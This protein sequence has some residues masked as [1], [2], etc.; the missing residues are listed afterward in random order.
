MDLAYNK[1]GYPQIVGGSLNLS[2]MNVRT[3]MFAYG[4]RNRRETTFKETSAYGILKKD[5]DTNEE[6]G[7]DDTTQ[8]NDAKKAAVYR[9]YRL[10]ATDNGE[11]DKTWSVLD[12]ETVGEDSYAEKGFRELSKMTMEEGEDDGGKKEGMIWAY[13]GSNWFTGLKSTQALGFQFNSSG[14]GG[15]PFLVLSATQT[16]LDTKIKDKIKALTCAFQSNERLFSYKSDEVLSNVNNNSYLP[17]AVRVRDRYRKEDA[18]NS[19]RSKPDGTAT[20]TPDS[21]EVI[22][23]DQDDLDKWADNQLSRIAQQDISGTLI[24]AGIQRNIKEGMTIDNIMVQESVTIPINATITSVRYDF[25]DLRT[26]L[27]V[28]QI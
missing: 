2:L 28:G 14:Q 27:T 19:Y 16:I 17:L 15:R 24:I 7:W 12:K 6:S 26:H 5:W 9:R 3:R 10:N 25:T 1:T 22:R 11:T 18:V 20:G 8:G 23:N 4:G 21:P 13:D